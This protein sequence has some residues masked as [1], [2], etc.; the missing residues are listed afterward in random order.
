METPPPKLNVFDEEAAHFTTA[1]DIENEL[2]EMATEIDGVN[3]NIAPPAAELLPEAQE[4][5]RVIELQFQN[6]L[7]LTR[8]QVEK[9]IAWKVLEKFNG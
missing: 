9:A 2:E 1:D 5:E 4:S 6:V 3:I 7:L 8:M